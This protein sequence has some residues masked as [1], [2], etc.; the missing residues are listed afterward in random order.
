RICC[1][2]L[3]PYKH[4]LSSLPL[5][6]LHTTYINTLSLH[7]AL[8]ISVTSVFVLLAAAVAF[9]PVLAD[10]FNWPG[11]SR[12]LPTTL[13][14]TIV[15]AELLDRKSTRLNSSHVSSSYA[16]YCLKKKKK[17]IIQKKNEIKRK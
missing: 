13:A 2:V 9:A 3:S 8:P 10:I 12:H 6:T 5:S 17:N 4:P 11:W 16:V 15:L 7:D 14:V 1:S